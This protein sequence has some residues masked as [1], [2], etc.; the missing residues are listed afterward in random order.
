MFHFSTFSQKYRGDGGTIRLMDDLGQFTGRDDIIMLGGGNPSR[1]S[2]VL[3]ATPWA[4]CSTATTTSRRSS[5]PTTAHPAATAPLWTRRSTSSRAATAGTS[6]RKTMALTNG[7]RTI[8]FFFIF[9]MFA[10]QFSDGTRKTFPLAPEYIGYERGH[11]RRHLHGGVP[12]LSGWTGGSSS[13]MW[14]STPSRWTRPSAP[15]VSRPTNPTGNVLTDAEIDRLTELAQ[16]HGIPLIID[17]AYGA[18]FPASSSPDAP[19]WT[20]D[21]LCMSLSKLGLPGAHGHHHRRRRHRAHHQRH[22]R[23]HQPR[24]GQLRRVPGAARCARAPSCT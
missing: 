7:S 21:H 14:T 22:E 12:S 17:N 3:P 23:G 20:L 24:A 4:A 13:T 11:R 6:A 2:G 8:T 18:P 5:A 10:G 15:S 19:R 9:N 1:P 16:T